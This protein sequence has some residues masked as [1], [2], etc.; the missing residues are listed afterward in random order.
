VRDL[1]FTSTGRPALRVRIGGEGPGLLLLHGFASGLE[2]WPAEEL[3]SLTRIR[4]VLAVDL[5]GHGGSQPARPG[6]ATPESLVDLLDAVRREYLGD[7]PV[8]WLGYSM[9]ARLA[10]TALSRG[11]RMGS[12]LLESPSPGIEDPMERTERARWD[13]EWARSFEEESTAGV[14]DRWLAQPIFD[15]RADLLPA[16]AAHQRRVRRSAHGPSLA[17]WLREFGSG[18]MPPTWEALRGALVPVRVAVG[19]RDETYV[20][21]AGRLESTAV[22]ARV[23]VI[24]GVGHAPHME[25]PAAW[26]RWVRA[27]LE[28]A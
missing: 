6:D 4:R 17:T 24:D 22:N 15:S 20:R 25:S 7:G 2:G 10:L 12:L 14:L 27:S 5:P 16:E 1:R 9:G 21:L 28:S 19:S 23:T 3:E 8:D 13:E 26:G 18:T 11:A